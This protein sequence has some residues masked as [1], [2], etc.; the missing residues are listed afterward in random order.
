MAGD[1]EDATNGDHGRGC[2][3]GVVGKA[4][5]AHQLRPLSRAECDP[6]PAP[7]S[8]ASIAG[9]GVVP[10]AAY[11]SVS[12][13]GSLSKMALGDALEKVLLGPEREPLASP[14]PDPDPCPT[15]APP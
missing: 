5:A 14:G 9:S 8:A 4:R 13:S 2:G 1:P 7:T 3:D 11:A 15:G 12:S 6:W 10:A